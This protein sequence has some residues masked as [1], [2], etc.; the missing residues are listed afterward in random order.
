MVVVMKMLIVEA[1]QFF[2]GRGYLVLNM[3]SADM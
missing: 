3:A 2:G 1:L